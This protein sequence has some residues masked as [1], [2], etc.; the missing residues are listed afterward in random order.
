M[1]SQVETGE[2]VFAVAE[3]PPPAPVAVPVVLA[4]VLGAVATGVSSL[5]SWIPSLWGDEAASA[6]S[7]QRSISSLSGML[8]HVDAVHGMYYLGLHAWVSLFGASPFSLRFP[9]AVAIG[10]TV[11]AVV[12]L[13]LRL[14]TARVAVA[15]GIVC[16]VVPRVTYMGEE[17]RSFAF[18]AAAVAWL[19]LVFVELIRRGGRSKRLW[20]GYGALLAFGIYVFLYVALFVVAHLVILLFSRL[21]PEAKRPFRRRWLLVTAA[22][23]VV[24]SP[25]IVFALLER[26][27]I[28]YLATAPQLDF[29]TLTIGLWFG[30]AGFA[31]VAW[32]LLIVVGVG[33]GIRLL[34]IW[35]DA[36]EQDRSRLPR[37]ELV[38]ASWLLV[39]SALLI[40]SQVLYS[41]FTARYLSFC[42]PAAA[43]LI[44]VGLDRLSARRRP[45][46]ALGVLVVVA[47]AVPAYLSQRQPYSKNNSDWANVSAALAGNAT[48]GDAVVFDETA[49]P[50]R[51][52][53][54]GMHT[55]PAGFAGL[56]DV[57][58][59][60]PYR[61]SSTWY[62]RAYS[63]DDAFALDRFDGVETLWLIEYSSR[64]RPDTYG[65]DR[66][67][68]AGF[69]V[70]RQIDE[71]RSVIYGM[72]R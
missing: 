66:L 19:T 67:Q 2:K 26:R 47:L 6:M 28:A 36:T 17:A 55:Y 42:A 7:A 69:H 57:T 49:R 41:D 54:L 53:R 51:R 34:G 48:P 65:L 72:T 68:A 60:T 14:S 20:I 46:L 11:S 33:A 13:A 58:L 22:A 70:M 10:F 9:S 16:A 12:L 24:A 15:A 27:Q 56:R 3:R 50:S 45:V 61:Q 29:S 44:A 4:V 5:G 63:V 1:H 8:T 35:T 37:L 32:L 18:S 31:I 38:A 62:D 23:F 30:T 59:K 64:T 52:P 40:A 71:H 25:V 43:I 39:P 21:P